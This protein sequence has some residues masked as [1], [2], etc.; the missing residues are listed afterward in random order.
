MSDELAIPMSTRL[1]AVLG[2]GGQT[3]T[4]V[5]VAKPTGKKLVMKAM[6][7]C[8]FKLVDEIN[9][10]L[11]IT[12]FVLHK[13][14]LTNRDD[15]EITEAVRLVLVDDKGRCYE[16]VA[17]TIVNSFRMH[18]ELYGA[19]PWHPARKMCV[20]KKQKGDRNIYWLDE[21]D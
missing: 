8:E 6:N 1:A 18:V 21:P 12:D 16:C 19:P 11:K 5:D 7:A 17:A 14:M 10:E 13:V 15:G 2:G 9:K 20:R 4:S 3:L